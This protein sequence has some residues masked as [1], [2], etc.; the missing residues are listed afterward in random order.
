MV[1]ISFII[2]LFC[3]DY[4][5]DDLLKVEGESRIE[6]VNIVPR[7]T[8]DIKYSIDEINSIQVKWKEIMQVRGWAFTKSG[9]TQDSIIRI[10]LKSKENT[11]ISE[12]TSESRP[13]VSVKF[14]DSNFD[15]D[16]SGFVSLIDESAI[17]NGKYNIGI[18]IENGVLK[19]FI[20]TNRFVTKTNKILY[21]RLISVEQKFE[22]PEETKRISL[23]VERV[24]ETS[25]M[26]NKFIEIEGW[27]FGEAQNTD[28]QQVYVV[29]KSDNGTYIYD[30]VSRK[31]PDVTNCYKRLKLNL[32]NSGFLAAIPKDELKRGKYEIG[33]YIK[34]DDVELLQ[35]S[36]KTVTI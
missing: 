1:F 7:E 25:D 13:E 9:N 15:L 12:T 22:V 30:T 28:N 29:L 6:R 2:Y 36:G 21:N 14:G 5:F 26:G 4:I 3:A 35:Y 32:D 20:F 33:I 34:K 31:R 8:D 18:I 19:S 10:V 27:A 24:Q 17:K 23:N 16:K 11:Y